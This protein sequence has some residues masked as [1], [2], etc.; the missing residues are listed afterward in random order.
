MCLEGV[1]LGAGIPVVVPP[2]AQTARVACLTEIEANHFLMNI[3]TTIH[4][5]TCQTY[6]AGNG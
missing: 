3:A 1:R 6:K 4:E 2:V 5:Q